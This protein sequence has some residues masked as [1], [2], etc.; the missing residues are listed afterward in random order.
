KNVRKIVDDFVDLAAKDA[1]AN[2]DR[3]GKHKLDPV[4]IADLKEQLVE[5]VSAASG[6]PLKYTGKS[7]KEAHKGMGITAAEFDALAADLKK[8]LEQNGVKAAEVAT[9]LKA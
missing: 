4:Q 3:N 6:G 7:M 5:F 9:V 1:K 2:L 8:A